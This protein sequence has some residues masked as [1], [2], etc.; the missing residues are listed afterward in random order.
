MDNSFTNSLFS[1]GSFTSRTRQSSAS[2]AI[3]GKK[4]FH[5]GFKKGPGSG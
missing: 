5:G 4:S 2:S 1:K 3:S